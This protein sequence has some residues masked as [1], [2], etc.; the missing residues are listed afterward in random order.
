MPHKY[1]IDI[2]Y[3]RLERDAQPV[4]AEAAHAQ[5]YVPRAAGRRVADTYRSKPLQLL[6]G[7]SSKALS[8]SEHVAG[9]HEAHDD[10][11][12]LSWGCEGYV[13]FVYIVEGLI[14]EVLFGHLDHV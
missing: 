5:E 10:A 6:T 12:E 7:A 11:W 2:V 9:E 13:V 8:A 4:S 1:S 14:L 3:Y